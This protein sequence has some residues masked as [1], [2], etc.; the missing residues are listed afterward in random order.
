MN[1][2]KLPFYFI[3]DIWVQRFLVFQMTKREFQNKY[4]GS[5]LGFL[6]TII[7]PFIMIFILWLVFT[8]GFHS[9]DIENIPFIAWLTCG[10]IVWDFFSTTLVAGTSVFSEY[11][12]LVKKIK[13]NVAILPLIKIF[14]ALITHGIML[15]IAIL[16]LFFSGVDFSWYWFQVFYYLFASFVLLLGLSWITSSFQVFLKDTAQGINVFIQFGFWLTP[17][18][19]NVQ[20]LPEKW[21]FWL[22]FHPIF[23]LVNG[24]R[25]SLLFEK[26]F[27]ENPQGMLFFWT[28][29]LII[30]LIAVIL[31]KK[32][33]PH[34]ADVL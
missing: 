24:Y 22:Y 10:L 13:F 5:Y 32:L 33:R 25:E 29:T 15:F 31:F 26:P 11:Q 2:L 8:K 28:I 20:L 17:I 9:G 19:W 27:W 34:F 4:I 6:W 7:Q 1:L 30:L 3:R 23:Y 12:Y 18:M 16:I 21:Q 14:S